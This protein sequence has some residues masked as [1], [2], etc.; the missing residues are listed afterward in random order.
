MLLKRF[1]LFCTLLLAGF[2]FPSD[3]ALAQEVVHFSG[4]EEPGTIV[5]RVSERRLYF[6]LGE[7]RALRYPVGVGRSGKQWFGSTHIVSKRIR[8]AWSPPAEIRGNRPAWIVP[9]GAPNNPMGAA[10]L[11]LADNELAIHGTNNPGSIGGFVSWGCVRMNNQH[12]M[13]L[14]NRV[15][16]STRVVFSD[17]PRK[18]I[19]KAVTQPP[20]SVAQGGVAS[21]K[22]A[23]VRKG[24]E[25]EAVKEMHAVAGP[26]YSLPAPP[27]EPSI[28]EPPSP[29]QLDIFN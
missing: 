24:E 11:V 3:R 19:A 25:A 16:V 13:D 22:P 21:V 9:A 18:E 7:G 29:S 2:A 15:S 14:Y 20:S 10:A 6:I 28:T 12:I 17:P 26:P 23:T 4:K 5:V 8:P 1:A 27:P